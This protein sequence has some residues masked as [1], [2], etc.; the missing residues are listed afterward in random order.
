MDAV[1]A[2][3]DVAILTKFAAFLLDTVNRF[4]AFLVIVGLGFLG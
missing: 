2:W 3:D 1:E 4:I